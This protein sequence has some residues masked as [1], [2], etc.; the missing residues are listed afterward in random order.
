V[1]A[2]SVELVRSFGFQPEH[3][4]RIA[5]DRGFDDDDI[6]A[7]RVFLRQ[8][9]AKSQDLG[10][11]DARAYTA[12]LIRKHRNPKEARKPWYQAEERSRRRRARGESPTVEGTE[13]PATNDEPTPKLADLAADLEREGKRVPEFV[14]RLLSGGS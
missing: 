9:I 3:A 1:N 11:R 8:T 7:W 10:I 2:I 14:Q 13:I 4:R 5:V 6:F 12:S